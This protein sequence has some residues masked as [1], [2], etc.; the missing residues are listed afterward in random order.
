MVTRSKIRYAPI[1]ARDYGLSVNRKSTPVRSV[2]Q[3]L[4]DSIRIGSSIRIDSFRTVV[5]AAGTAATHKM[6]I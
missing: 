2:R 3:P 5:Q 6:N 1:R 4:V